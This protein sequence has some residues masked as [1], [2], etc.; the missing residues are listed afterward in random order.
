MNSFAKTT[1][2]AMAGALLLGGCA[3]V[4]EG[5]RRVTNRNAVVAAPSCQNFSFP[6]YFETGADRLTGA[7]LQVIDDN[8]SRVKACPVSQVAVTGLA[9]AEGEA[10]ANMELSR[11]RAA[12]VAQALSARGY[13][14]P[15][16]D[17]GA[18]G[19]A[20]ATGPRGAAA[21]MRRA[22]QVSVT[23]ASQTPS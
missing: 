22:A 10:A 23:F 15:T 6:I 3:Q 4:S 19:E 17:V 20:G 1:T 5:V 2:A 21:P 14:T 13:P 9:D 8:S 16:F 12:T 11:R 18:A 7:A